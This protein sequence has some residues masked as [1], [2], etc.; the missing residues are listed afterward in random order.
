MP[1]GI[2]VVFIGRALVLAL[3]FPELREEVRQ[4]VVGLIDRQ[5]RTTLTGS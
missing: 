2:D 5:S 1:E 3:P 4:A